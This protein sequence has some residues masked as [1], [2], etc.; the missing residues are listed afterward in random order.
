MR[1]RSSA[2]RA[3]LL[4]LSLSLGA[5]GGGQASKNSKDH[6]LVDDWERRAAL[7][8]KTSGELPKAPA[9]ETP[10]STGASEGGDAAGGPARAI[11]KSRRG[12]LKRA[13]LTPILDKRLGAFL[14][15]VETAPTMRAGQFVGF[16][17]VKFFPGNATMAAVDLGPGDIVTGIN[18]MPIGRPEQA[19]RVWQA[20]RTAGQLKV[21]YLRDGAPLS[22]EYLIE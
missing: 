5:C 15:N 13:E 16:R 14:R 22:L 20:L 21:D 10:P 2:R 12:V 6:A 17:L 11:E 18:G 19:L 1:P 8:A 3:G 9:D 7:S 4:L